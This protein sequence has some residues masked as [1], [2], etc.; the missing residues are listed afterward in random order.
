M[1]GDDSYRAASR[2]D[3]FIGERDQPVAWSSDAAAV[4]GGVKGG[5]RKITVQATPS[6]DALYMPLL[7]LQLDR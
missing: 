1:G 7:L 5:F 3:R 2:V 4:G 6:R